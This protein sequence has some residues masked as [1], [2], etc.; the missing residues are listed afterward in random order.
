MAEKFKKFDSAFKYEDLEAKLSGLT[1]FAGYSFNKW[2]NPIEFNNLLYF[3]PEGY[4]KD[5]KEN[6]ELLELIY[7]GS[8]ESPFLLTILAGRNDT[9]KGT[10]SFDID[11]FNIAPDTSATSSYFRQQWHHYKDDKGDRVAYEINP[12]LISD[13]E[14]KKDVT[15]NTFLTGSTCYSTL[16]EYKKDKSVFYSIHEQSF[17]KLKL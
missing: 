9:H 2:N 15:Y 6:L 10:E 13:E 17:G 5:Q 14:R 12:Y 8:S 11:V 3:L 16:E 7:S 4:A 1:A